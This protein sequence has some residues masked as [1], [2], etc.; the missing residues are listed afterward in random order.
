MHTTRPFTEKK[1]YTQLIVKEK[2]I[3]TSHSL[4]SCAYKVYAQ[5]LHESKLRLKI[6]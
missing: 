6:I 3:R 5:V 1:L 2:N 4:S